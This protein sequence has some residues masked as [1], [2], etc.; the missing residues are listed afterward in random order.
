MIPS[1]NLVYEIMS[2]FIVAGAGVS[3]LFRPDVRKR[4]NVSAVISGTEL[5]Y[6]FAVSD[7]RT[8]EVHVWWVGIGDTT[9]HQS[10]C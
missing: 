4:K 1:L 2:C 7:G 6:Q 8:D 3:F 10:R 5:C 9:S